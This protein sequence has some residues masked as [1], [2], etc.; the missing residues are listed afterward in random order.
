MGKG[1]NS[2]CCSLDFT[3]VFFFFF[4]FFTYGITRCK[5]VHLLL[6][7]KALNPGA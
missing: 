5:K 6:V 7:S 1:L 4:L 2:A 3:L